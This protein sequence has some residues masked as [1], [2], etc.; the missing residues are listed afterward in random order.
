[1]HVH[2][3]ETRML[4]KQPGIECVAVAPCCSMLLVAFSSVPLCTLTAMACL[5]LVVIL[6]AHAPAYAQSLPESCT[7]VK[8]AH[9][10]TTCLR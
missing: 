10:L 4:S 9:E 2:A 3:Y 8:R 6:L 5:W 7:V 1:M